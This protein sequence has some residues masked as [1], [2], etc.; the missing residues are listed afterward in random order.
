[1]D[2]TSPQH[3]SLRLCNLWWFRTPTLWSNW[4]FLP[5]VRH[6]PDGDCELGL[7]YDACGASGTFGFSATVFLANLFVLPR[8]EAEFLPLPRCVYDTPEEIFEAG[9]RVD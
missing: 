8:A 3:E 5:L 2:T 6:P 7:L 4:P 1:M 9:W